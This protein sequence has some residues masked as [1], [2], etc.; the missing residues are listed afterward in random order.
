VSG[1]PT[2]AVGRVVKAHGVHGEVAVENRSDNPERWS[3]GSVV[4]DD[5][6]EPLTVRTA[7]PHQ[8]RLLVTFDEIADRTAA[9]RLLGVTLVVPASALPPLEPGEWWAFEA[10][11]MTVRTED[12]RELGRVQEVLAYPAHDLWR[13]VGPDGGEILVP[14]VDAFL[15]S[16]D[17]GAGRAV[18][19]SVPGLT[20][21]DA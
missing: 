1:E 16:V 6:G 10:E 2:V 20:A 18:V 12:G 3:P 21:P 11:G 14:V 7:R 8:N 5:R 4:L 13:I 19:R 15:V 17:V 9:E